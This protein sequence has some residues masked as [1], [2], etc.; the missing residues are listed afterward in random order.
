[1]SEVGHGGGVLETGK[2]DD[3]INKMALSQ[4]LHN[5]HKKPGSQWSHVFDIFWRWAADNLRNL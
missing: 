1:M 3:L 5:Q 2:E 4:N